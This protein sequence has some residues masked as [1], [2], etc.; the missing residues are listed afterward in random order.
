MKTAGRKSHLWIGKEA[1]RGTADTPDFYVPWATISNPDNIT[2]YARNTASV[3]RLEQIDGAD[4]IKIRGEVGFSAKIKD[5]W[6]GLVLLSLLG[7]D[8]P[9][10]RVAPN[11]A[12]Y[13]HTYSVN[14][15]VQHQS[16]TIG[17]KDDNVDYA[18]PNAVVGSLKITA[19]TGNYVMATVTTMSKGSVSATTTPSYTAKKD[20][21]PQQLVF[22]HAANQASLD[23]A[24][25][26]SIRSFSID[27]NTNVMAEENLGSV[28]PTDILNQTVTI[29]GS[30]T[31]TYTDET[32]KGYQDAGTYRALRFDF[33]SDEV[34]GTSANP[35][36]KI[37]LHQAF[38]SGWSKDL[39]Q[40]GNVT[41][42]FNF[43][44]TLSL[45]DA[46]MATVILTNLVTAY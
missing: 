3:G 1:V 35:E 6:F 4:V 33:I 45:T 19:D 42:T 27:F 39:A 46:K 43:E 29:T 5:D 26:V 18:F 22:K 44:A 15:T 40:D 25:A 30:I 13:D 17:I 38:I 32:F 34:I 37:D 23:A 28:S 14:Q 11:T 12:V 8:S 21:K 41:E 16:L 31:K 36:L 10:A 24:S 9:V 7:T 2:E 20:F